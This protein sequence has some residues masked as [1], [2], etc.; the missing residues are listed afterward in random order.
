MVVDVQVILE[1]LRTLDDYVRLLEQYRDWDARQLTEDRITYGGV[2][3]H[4]QLSAQIVLDVSAHLNAEL[5][6]GH[7]TDYREAVRSL[8]KH[9]VLPADFAR[10]IAAL[11]GF[12]NVLVHEYLTVDPLKVEKVLKDG[13][14]D[15]KAFNIYVTDFL[16]EEGYLQRD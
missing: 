5:G 4:L 9:G 2:L 7:A 11:S 1:R 12:R 6:L 15:L 16:K 3:H 8:G 13:L 14:A 10:R